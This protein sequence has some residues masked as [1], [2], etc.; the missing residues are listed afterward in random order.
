MDAR[1]VHA[2]TGRCCA[3]TTGCSSS[4]RSAAF[5]RSAAQYARAF[6]HTETD[7]NDLTYFIV[8]QVD[9]IRRAID[10]LDEYL[11]TKVRHVQR[12]ERMLRRSTDLNHRQ[13]RLLAHAVRQPRTPST[14]PGR[15]RRVTTSPMRRPAP[16]CSGSRN[17]GSSISGGWAG[18]PTSFARRPTSRPDC[19]RSPRP[20]EPSPFGRRA[21][22]DPVSLGWRPTRRRAVW[23]PSL[24]RR[25]D[26]V[27]HETFGRPGR[28]DAEPQH[29]LPLVTTRWRGSH[30]LATA[31]N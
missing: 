18:A 24:Y 21:A 3:T 11:E 23:Y 31:Q 5:S 19:N 6:L 12:V 4:S 26:G 17:S 15:T 27:G 20:T 2:S 8:H 28:G 25:R 30:S 14:R 7:G 16:I 22:W 13:L 9:V 10:E 29:H 1:P